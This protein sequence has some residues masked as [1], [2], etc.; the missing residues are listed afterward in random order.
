VSLYERYGKRAL[1]LAVGG[2]A[3]V[4][5]APVVGAAAA[6]LWRTQGR[7]I[8]FTQTRCGKDER[9][10]TIFKFRTMVPDAAAHG[11]GMWFERGDSRITPVGRF[12][13]ASS[14]DELPQIWNVLRGDMSLVGPRPKPH[15]VIDRYMSRYRE[16][17]RVRPGLTCLAAVEGR[18]TLRRSQMIDADQRYAR[19]LGLLTDLRIL[20]RTVPTVLLRRGFHSDDE[21]EEFV[22]DVPPD[23]APA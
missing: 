11:A 12:L 23:G 2:V 15:E 8:I 7:P 13:R 3:G 19:E 16:T 4:I 6:V 18:N 14:I 17:L 10:F 9:D 22:E 21:S 1:D 20:A 5:A